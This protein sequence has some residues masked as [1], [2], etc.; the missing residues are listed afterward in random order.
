MWESIMVLRNGLHWMNEHIIKF[1]ESD[2]NPGSVVLIG[3]GNPDRGDDGF[4]I[5]LV[6]RLKSCCPDR[7]FSEREK[8]VEGIVVELLEREE[9]DTFVFVDATDFGG[10]PGELKIFTAEDVDR[11]VPALS[12]H[13]VNIS[14]LIQL[15]QQHGRKPFLI[16]IQPKSVAFM[17]EMS[18]EIKKVIDWL[19]ASLH[20][21]FTTNSERIDD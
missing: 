7:V 19:E 2:T 21:F 1:F 9:I 11:F 13:K 8:S 5:D 10:N 16:G 3:L 6:G 4:G 12:T 20:K 14:I 18:P 15:I 17:E